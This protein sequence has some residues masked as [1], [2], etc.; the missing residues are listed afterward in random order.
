MIP[1]IMI[2]YQIIENFEIINIANSNKP[3][4]VKLPF[5]HRPSTSQLLNLIRR[6]SKD[7][8]F[9]NSGK[10]LTYFLPLISIASSDLSGIVVLTLPVVLIR[11]NVSLSS[12]CLLGVRVTHSWI[13]AW[14]WL[15]R[16]LIGNSVCS[17]KLECSE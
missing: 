13:E 15:L 1:K 12:F 6:I 17:F 11:S 9:S 2:Q 16:W 10:I 3:Y 7:T 4:L 5:N 8:K 14:F